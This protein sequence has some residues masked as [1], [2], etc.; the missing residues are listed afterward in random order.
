MSELLTRPAV[1]ADARP[2]GAPA[3]ALDAFT[4]A[5]VDEAAAAAYE[6]GLADG[7]ERARAH[8]AAAAARLAS[9][10]ESACAAASTEVRGLRAAQIDADIELASA[11]AEAILGREPSGDA[12]ALLTRVRTALER[13]DDTDL[14]IHAHPEHAEALA[15]A[16]RG[17]G[18][19][20][21]VHADGGL[22]PDEARITGRWAR[23]DLTR[24]AAL[25]T[26]RAALGGER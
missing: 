13:I 6:R 25:A 18:V 9:A 26:V 5:R 24:A 12:A 22:G 10:L 8:A 2:L 11:I 17:T 14:T 23:A 3:P 19:A 7:A 1:L 21:T 15:A 4:R 20:A 16:L